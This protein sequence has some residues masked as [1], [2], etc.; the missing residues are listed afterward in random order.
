MSC[1]EESVAPGLHVVDGLEGFAGDERAQQG[2]LSGVQGQPLEAHAVQVQQVEGVVD[3]RRRGLEAPEVSAGYGIG[4]ALQYL[5]VWEPV[6]AEGYD[7]AVE[8]HLVV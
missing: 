6:L 7:L 3:D 2:L 8:Y 4:V 1:L 5:E